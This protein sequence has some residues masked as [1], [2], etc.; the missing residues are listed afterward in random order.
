[1]CLILVPRVAWRVPLGMESNPGLS[2]L[3]SAHS[4]VE[5]GKGGTTR[6]KVF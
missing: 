6:S 2:N 3:Q 4:V 1:M 5:Y